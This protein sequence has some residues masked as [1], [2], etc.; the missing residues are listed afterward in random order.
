MKSKPPLHEMSQ[1][2]LDRRLAEARQEVFALRLQRASG[3]LTNPAR[4]AL[5]RRAIA[6]LLTEARARQGREPATPG[7]RP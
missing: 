2:E 7:G 4:V 5:V 1:A 6:R 3:K